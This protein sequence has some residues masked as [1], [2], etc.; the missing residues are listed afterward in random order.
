[1]PVVDSL[2]SKL[3]PRH[4]KYLDYLDDKKEFQF[5]QVCMYEGLCMVSAEGMY[6]FGDFGH[7]GGL[8]I[9]WSLAEVAK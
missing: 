9:V 1:M 2:G 4:K 7:L 8:L 6:S 3:Q 5:Q